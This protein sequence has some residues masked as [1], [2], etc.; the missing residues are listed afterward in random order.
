MG[1]Q[2]ATVVAAALRHSPRAAFPF[3]PDPS[4]S[5]PQNFRRPGSPGSRRAGGLVPPFWA[6][7]RPAQI[8]A[9]AGASSPLPRAVRPAPGGAR[10]GYGSVPGR[11]GVRRDAVAASA[12]ASLGHFNRLETR[13][14]RLSSQVLASHKFELQRYSKGSQPS[15]VRERWTSWTPLARWIMR[16][17]L[18]AAFFRAKK[19]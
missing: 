10:A 6:L 17:V 8:F 1:S 19:P 18:F 16:V 3:P 11:P 12:Q 4:P 7:A 13:E 14:S 2:W 5:A 15:D 9:L